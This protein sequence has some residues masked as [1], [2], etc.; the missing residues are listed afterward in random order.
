MNHLYQRYSRVLEKIYLRSIFVLFKFLLTCLLS[1]CY[2]LSLSFSCVFLSVYTNTR[3]CNEWINV[4]CKNG[5]LLVFPI[6]SP[7]FSSFQTFLFLSFSFVCFKSTFPFLPCFVPPPIT[8]RTPKLTQRSCSPSWSALAR[9]RLARCS[10]ASTIAHRK[11]WPS[12]SLTWRKR[13][14][15]LKTFSRRSQCW[16][17]ATAPLSPSTTAHTWRWCFYIYDVT[18]QSYSHSDMN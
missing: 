4:S 15:R 7:T 5:T 1:N 8:A 3:C 2:T 6:Y 13:K 18:G 14:T 11:W 17:S 9:A 12:R 16:A 10:K